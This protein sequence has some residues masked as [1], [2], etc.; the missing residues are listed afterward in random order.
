MLARRVLAALKARL[1][2]RLILLALGAWEGRVGRRLGEAAPLS[3]GA[4]EGEG[5]LA[6]VAGGG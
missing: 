5:P 3:P 1:R 6:W 2:P 4:G